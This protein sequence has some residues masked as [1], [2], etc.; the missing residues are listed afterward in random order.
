MERIDTSASSTPS[1]F[2][3]AF[4]L[5]IREITDLGEVV[6]DV[7]TTKRQQ[8]F[9]KKKKHGTQLTI[10]QI[11]SQIR[12]NRPHCLIHRKASLHDDPNRRH[13]KRDNNEVPNVNA[14]QR[15]GHEGIGEES[16]YTGRKRGRGR[17]RAFECADCENVRV[18]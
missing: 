6:A 14:E 9:P 8:P 10:M 13:N 16:R 1:A 3:R 12:N 2:S 11:R 17:V 5:S 15:G 7:S 4:D 18:S